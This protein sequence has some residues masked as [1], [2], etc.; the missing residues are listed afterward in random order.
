MFILF[1]LK[2]NK[3]MLQTL[4]NKIHDSVLMSLLAK[5]SSM[6]IGHFQ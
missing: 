4:Y 5:V 6:I 3:I 2:W 1:I